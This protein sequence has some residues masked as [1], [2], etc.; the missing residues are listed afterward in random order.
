[1]NNFVVQQVAIVVGFSIPMDMWQMDTSPGGGGGGGVSQRSQV[2]LNSKL[3][4][5]IMESHL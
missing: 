4:L 5:N 2:E 1:M 3:D